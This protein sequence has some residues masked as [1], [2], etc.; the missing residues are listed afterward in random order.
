MTTDPDFFFKFILP[1]F[2]GFGILALVWNIYNYIQSQKGFLKLK[3][4]CSSVIEGNEK[5]IVSKT[6]LENTSRKPIYLMHAFL[7]IVKQTVPIDEYAM[8]NIGFSAGKKKFSESESNDVA[9]FENHV[10]QALGTNDFIVK[11]LPYYYISHARLGSLA[12]MSTT[13]I[14]KMDNGGVYSIYF[15]IVG[16]DWYKGSRVKIN[17]KS[18][19]SDVTPSQARFVHDEVIVE[20][21]TPTVE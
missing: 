12:H 16:E 11:I 4:E 7:L 13:H 10:A 14:Q 8:S 9:D 3:L 21:I 2:S 1:V 20:Y 19:K 15:S 17:G 5:Y 18:Q 6:F